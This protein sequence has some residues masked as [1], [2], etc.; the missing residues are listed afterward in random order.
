M[1]YTLL[2][3]R[4]VRQKEKERLRDTVRERQ[5]VVLCGKWG[6]SDGEVSVNCCGLA[7][8][9]RPIT[10]YQLTMVEHTHTNIHTHTCTKHRAY[11]LM[12]T[13]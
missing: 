3:Y 1:S 9:L 11:P 10:T 7:F 5:V 2:I 8:S 12:W 6:E 13:G 4:E